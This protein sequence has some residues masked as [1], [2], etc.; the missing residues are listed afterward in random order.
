MLLRIPLDLLALFVETLKGRFANAAAIFRGYAWVITHMG[1]VLRKRRAIQKS[2]KIS[3]ATVLSRMYRG[4]IVFEYFLLGKKRFS[5][6]IFIDGLCK[7]S[8]INTEKTTN[9]IQ[10]SGVTLSQ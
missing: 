10:T 5:D 4:S 9:S 6:L 2:R 1:T 8:A 3:D 7:R